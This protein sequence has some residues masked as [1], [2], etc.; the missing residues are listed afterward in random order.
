MQDMERNEAMRLTDIETGGRGCVCAVR[1]DDR[2][3]SR[4]FSM[5]VTEGC[6][7]AVVQNRKKYPVLVHVRDSAIAIDRSDCDR[8]E[9]EVSR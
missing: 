2:F 7:F 6:R 4:I 5:G 1:G 3:L 8:I 9:V